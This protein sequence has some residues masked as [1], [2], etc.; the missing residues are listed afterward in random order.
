MADLSRY[1][2]KTS[3]GFL[4]CL[5]P[6]SSGPVCSGVWPTWIGFV[7]ARPTGWLDWD[8]G[9]LEARFPL[10]LY[11]AFL[12]LFLSSFYCVSGHIVLLGGA[13]PLGSV[14]AMGGCTWS[15]TVWMGGVCQVASTWRPGLEVSQQYIES[16]QDHRCYSCYLSVF[17]TLWLI[18]V[19]TLNS[20][21]GS[22]R[23]PSNHLKKL[24]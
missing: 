21:N 13:V 8:L 5:A 1:G 4:L 22:Q 11:F 24:H 23:R 6:G 19:T 9:D 7:L 16:L 2:H 14:D 20:T 3:G 10:G 12:K 18:S 17:L 15:T